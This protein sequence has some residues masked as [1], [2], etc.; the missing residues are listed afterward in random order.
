MRE[1]DGNERRERD[2]QTVRLRERKNGSGGVGTV[3]YIVDFF[4]FLMVLMNGRVGRVD[5]RRKKGNPL[6]A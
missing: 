1:R 5:T 2:D 4:F 3:G 6:P